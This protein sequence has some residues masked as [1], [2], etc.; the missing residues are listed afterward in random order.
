[1][2]EKEKLYHRNYYREY[3]R[4]YRK[5]HK[6]N[7]MVLLLILLNAMCNKCGCQITKETKFQINHIDH[8]HNNNLRENL[9]I[10]CGKCGYKETAKYRSEHGG[11]YTPI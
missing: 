2:S 9:E 10:L 11:N 5:N 4:N 1:M 8:N 3:M 7:N 6:D